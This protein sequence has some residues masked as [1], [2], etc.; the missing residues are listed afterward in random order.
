MHSKRAVCAGKVGL[1]LFQVS[2]FYHFFFSFLFY[3][4]LH[5]LYY[6]LFSVIICFFLQCLREDTSALRADFCLALRGD[7]TV[8][9][10]EWFWKIKNGWVHRIL[11]SLHLLSSSETSWPRYSARAFNNPQWFHFLWSSPVSPRVP[12]GFW[13]SPYLL[14]SSSLNLFSA[15]WRKLFHLFP[16]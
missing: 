16:L 1:D 2:F 8:A 14:A 7:S 6:F 13:H 5:L 12:V 10:W 11:S 15:T 4:H 3:L 9:K